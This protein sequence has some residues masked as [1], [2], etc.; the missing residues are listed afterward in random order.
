MPG[1]PAAPAGPFVGD[2][3]RAAGGR[4]DRVVDEAAGVGEGPQQ[5]LG[6]AMPA[7]VG[8]E[9]VRS[10]SGGSAAR[11]SASLFGARSGGNRRENMR[12]C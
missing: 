1:R 10:K 4:R 12:L 8:S 9:T 2:R 11:R 6:N 5:P 3:R 7:R